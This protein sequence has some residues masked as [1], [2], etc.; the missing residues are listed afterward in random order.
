MI[1]ILLLCYLS[2]FLC[3]CGIFKNARKEKEIKNKLEEK[4]KLAE[5]LKAGGDFDMINILPEEIAL[6]IKPEIIE[7]PNPFPARDSVLLDVDSRKRIQAGIL[8]DHVSSRT[9]K[10]ASKQISEKL[11]SNTSIS[12]GQSWLFYL[13]GALCVGGIVVCLWIKSPYSAGCC[14]VGAIS[15]MLLPSLIEAI[16]GALKG[17]VY[18]FNGC[19]ALGFAC[20]V[21]W[22]FYKIYNHQPDQLSNQEKEV[23]QLPIEK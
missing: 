6:E 10:A 21:A 7:L 16:H 23:K 15:M 14:G 5:I 2:C 12:S 9:L 17:L 22:V 1:K 20:L 13:L 18:L 4:S 11:E 8:Y 3:G 19:L